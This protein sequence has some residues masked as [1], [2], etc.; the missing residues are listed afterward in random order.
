MD[1]AVVDFETSNRDRSSICQV[2]IASFADGSLVDEW[3]SYVNPEECFEPGNTRVHGITAS[4]VAGAPRLPDIA[5]EITSRISQTLVVSHTMCDSVSLSRGFSKYGLEV[6]VCTWLDSS[7]VAKRAWPQY[8]RKGYGLLNLCKHIGYEFSAHDALEDAKAAG[9][10]LLAASELAG[11]NVH[12]WLATA[13]RPIT[14]RHYAEQS[15]SLEPNPD[16]PLFGEVALFTGA[17]PM[18]REDAEALAAAL[19]CQIAK[20]PTKKLTMLVV[21]ESPGGKLA[22]TQAMIDDGYEIEI[23]TPLDFAELVRMV[24]TGS[25]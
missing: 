1:F 5:P 11:L 10:V 22:K 21:G 4:M 17:L 8:S 16:G 24:D 18:V 2:G 12:D 19:G 23:L 7:R 25:F 20:S 3:K 14:T 6:P 15:A 9:F 13:A